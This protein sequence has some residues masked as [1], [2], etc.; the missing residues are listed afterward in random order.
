MN[1]ILKRCNICLFISNVYLSVLHR[2]HDPKKA[3]KDSNA[4]FGGIADK[5]SLFEGH[6]FD[7]GHNKAFQAPRSAD[8]SP[9]RKVTDRLKA[10]FLLSEQRSRS[11]E[12]YSKT[13]TR[14]PSPP[15]KPMSIKERLR[16][17]AEVSQSEAKPAPSH[18]PAM[19]G[20][21]QKSTSTVVVSA[22]KSSE[23]DNRDKLDAK[24][25]IHAKTKSGITSKP[26]GQDTTAV[27]VQIYTP[28]AQLKD[29]KTKEVAAS[30][31]RENSA[32]RAEDPSGSVD[33]TN[34]TSPHSQGPSR[35]GSRSKKRKGRETT[36]PISPN[37][38]NKPKTLEQVDG[39]EETPASKQ[40]PE[41]VLLPSDKDPR[42]ASEK[43]LSNDPV[44]NPLN[45]QAEELEKQKKLL[46]TSVKKNNAN[47]PPNRQGRS[48]KPAVSKDKPD[49]AAC[50]SGTK[51]TVD[52]EPAL[53]PQKE[54][55][56]GEHGLPFTSERKNASERSGET[57]ASFPSAGL[58]VKQP[59]EKSPAATQE[60]L[61]EKPKLDKE[62][63]MQLESTCKGKGRMPGKEDQGQQAKVSNRE[64][65]ISGNEEG[66][67]E[68]KQ[69]QTACQLSEKADGSSAPPIQTHLS[70]QLV[71]THPLK[72]V[73]CPVAPS[74]EAG[75]G[76][77]SHKK[78]QKVEMAE[79]VHSELQK[80]STESSGTKRETL[81]GVEPQSGS[82]SVEKTENSLNDSCAHEAHVAELSSLEYFTKA[83]PVDEG[84]SSKDDT[85]MLTDFTLKAKK[86]SSSEEASPI[87]QSKSTSTEVGQDNWKKS[88]DVKSLYPEGK[89][90][91]EILRPAVCQPGSEALQ[92][93]ERTS[94]IPS[95]KEKNTQ[96][97][98]D[99]IA[100]SCIVKEIEK[101]ADKR[102]TLSVNELSPTANGE[103]SSESQL[104]TVKNRPVND[105]TSQASKASALP[106]DNKLIPGKIPTSSMKKLHLPQRLSKDDSSKQQDAPSSWLDVDLP[107]HKFK[108]QEAKLTSFGSENNL[109]DTSG[110]LD[111]NDFVERIR[112]L[113][114]PFSLPPR[115][116]N[117]LRPPQPPFAM[118]AIREDR[119]EKTFDPEEFTFGLRK[120]TQFS[121]DTTRGLLAK[122]QSTETKSGIIARASVAD[123]SLLLSSLDTHSRL[124]DKNPIKDED[125]KEEKDDQIK[126][127]S[128]LERSGILNSLTTSSFR[129]KRNGVQTETDN[130]GSGNASPSSAPQVSPLLLPQ[131]SPPSPTS[132]NKEPLAKQSREEARAAEAVVSDS[133]PPLPSFND[134]KLPGYLEK[135]FPRDPPI[136]VQSTQEQE[137]V[138]PEVSFTLLFF[139]FFLMEKIL[140][141]VKMRQAL[142]E[143]S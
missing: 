44:Q 124:R 97:P 9:V 47:E 12:R 79:N 104:C 75:G 101:K 30:K 63:P 103:M 122:L 39:T 78:H 134:I 72:A 43:L 34:T 25:Q 139:F 127:K 4:G 10:D 7:G 65:V 15:D 57:S 22:S 68:A 106:E 6:R 32:E 71:T 59:L 52:S 83:T 143:Q 49:T 61:V 40:L 18:M 100:P 109:L 24:E 131:P 35:T 125:V 82:G 86:D 108:V 133:G 99:N 27:G 119:F 116:H 16:K 17:F 3:G 142:V 87:S 5:I 73:I 84:V 115:K 45:K 58:L 38:Q 64:R 123:R 93:T 28:E 113:C 14:S 95:V 21:S 1:F 140:I 66:A 136:P 121:L 36:S 55:I 67:D 56:S 118:P 112:N 13:R 62:V 26:D 130:T 132:V 102:F 69:P 19:T 77:E 117:P 141:S 110:E 81:I 23:L 135:Y 11:A 137:K 2:P 94:N 20:M 107:K 76:S 85:L 114:A 128:R 98:S 89:I 92:N 60:S 90:S 46:D 138:K 29:S 8:V 53:L 31:E 33:L 74:N 41:K 70:N 51:K 126:V 129:S 42:D 88:P 91:G 50:S 54:E 96:N 80:Q 48:P 105:K 37:N 111:D 120:K